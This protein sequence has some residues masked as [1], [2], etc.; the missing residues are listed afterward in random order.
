M[1]HDF[2]TH[3][4]G[5]GTAGLL[6]SNQPENSHQLEHLSIR[7]KTREEDATPRRIGEGQDEFD[8]SVSGD[9]ASGKSNCL[10]ITKEV[11]VRHE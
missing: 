6:N 8:A 3:Y 2:K 7:A 11:K 10:L 9:A 1:F 4:G 5:L